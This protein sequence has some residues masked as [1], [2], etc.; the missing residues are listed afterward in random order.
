MNFPY[1]ISNKYPN[2]V[3]YTKTWGKSFTE[4]P[5]PL[6]ITLMLSMHLWRL[7]VQVRCVACVSPASNNTEPDRFTADNLSNTIA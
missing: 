2:V 1:C 6:N 7:Q 4:A 5:Q 3:I